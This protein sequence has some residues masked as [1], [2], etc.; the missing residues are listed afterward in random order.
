MASKRKRKDLPRMVV[1]A[2]GINTISSQL[3]GGGRLKSHRTVVAGEVPGPGPAMEAHL[4][5]ED[6]ATQSAC[7]AVAFS[8][9]LGDNSLSAETDNEVNLGINVVWVLRGTKIP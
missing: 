7:A 9:D 3:Q 1:G 6:L 5:D 4:W 2:P 8:Y